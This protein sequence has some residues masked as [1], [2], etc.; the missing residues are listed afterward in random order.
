MQTKVLDIFNNN[1]FSIP[2]YQRDYAWKRQNLDDLWE[3]LLEAE[4]CK[5]DTMGHFLGTIVISKNPKNPNVYDIIDG[6]QRATTIFMLRYA[7]NYKT[8]DPKRNINYFLDDNDE[9]RLRLIKKNEEFFKNI[10]KQAEKWERNTALEKEAKT[11]GQKRL[12]EV[13][14]DILDKINNLNQD[15]AKEKLEV[16]N[17]MVLMRL[18]EKD[19]GR[20]IR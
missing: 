13:F 10:L 4:L 11:D 12:Y 6:Q 18:E 5:N 19:S 9:P 2:D 3:D 1:I 7:L 14:S 8:K 17:N 20:A 15:E 16:L